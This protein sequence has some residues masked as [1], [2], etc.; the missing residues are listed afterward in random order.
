[1]DKESE[2][3]AYLRKEIPKISEAKMKEG[4]FVGPQIKQLLEDHDFSTKLNATERRTWEA[5]E[6]ACRTFLGSEKAENY[7]DTV[8]ELV[9]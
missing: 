4:I 6:K 8:Q 2:D 5:F 1:M 7:S 9:S 3:F